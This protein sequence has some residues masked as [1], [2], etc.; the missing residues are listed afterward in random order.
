ML[1]SF[2]SVDDHGYYEDEKMAKAEQCEEE[3]GEAELKEKQ[4]TKPTDNGDNENRNRE[5]HHE[6]KLVPRVKDREC[7][8][9]G[10]VEEHFWRNRMRD[11]SQW[12]HEAVCNASQYG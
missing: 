5:N 4:E 8:D 2:S 7:E 9:D 3:E 6:S 10:V 11:D 12:P 1:L